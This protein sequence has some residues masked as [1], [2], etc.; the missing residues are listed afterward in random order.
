MQFGPDGDFA[1]GALDEGKWQVMLMSY[2]TE[3]ATLITD[4]PSAPREELTPFEVL[5]DGTLKLEFSGSVCC[6]ERIPELSF[7]INKH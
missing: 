2:R 4:Q 6:F 7:E 5:S 1:Y 3:G